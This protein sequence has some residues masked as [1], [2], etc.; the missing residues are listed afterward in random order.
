MFIIQ[1]NSGEIQSEVL[2]DTHDV[3]VNVSEDVSVNV[4]NDIIT[5]SNVTASKLAEKHSLTVRQI[6]RILAHLQKENKIIRVGSDK[7][8]HWEVICTSNATQ[9][10]SIN[11]VDVVENEA[12]VVKG[13]S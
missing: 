8:G 3:S 11:N 2:N 1:P 10:G 5:D 12:D 9:S 4:L 6:Y 13:N 7:T